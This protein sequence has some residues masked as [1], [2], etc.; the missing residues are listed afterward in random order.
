MP[1]TCLFERNFERKVN[2]SL[3]IWKGYP[4]PEQQGDRHELLFS[5]GIHADQL[6]N[7][8]IVFFTII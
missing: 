6:V 1:V 3:I 5:Q 2:A 4:F 8:H 7:M